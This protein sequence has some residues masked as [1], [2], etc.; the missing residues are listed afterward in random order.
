MGHP[1]YERT[2]RVILWAY[3]G[4][5]YEDTEDTEYEDAEDREYMRT[6]GT[7]SMRTQSMRTHGTQTMR[8]QRI[9][10][11]EEMTTQSTLRACEDIE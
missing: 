4:T 9:Y 10:S 6:Q 5:D 2:Q 1:V 8:I 7:H 11:Y 3:E